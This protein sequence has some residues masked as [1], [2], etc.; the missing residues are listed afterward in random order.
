MC[1]IEQVGDAECL[2]WFMYAS[3]DGNAAWR[4]G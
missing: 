4:S 1:I 3:N 2:V